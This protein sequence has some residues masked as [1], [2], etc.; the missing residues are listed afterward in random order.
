MNDTKKNFETKEYFSCLLMWLE[1][2]DK[3]NKSINQVA[4]AAKEMSSHTKKETAN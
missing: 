2:L 4:G 3:V 1:T